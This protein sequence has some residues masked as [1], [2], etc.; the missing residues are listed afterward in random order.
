MF[1]NI[2][3]LVLFSTS[4][5]SIFSF[6]KIDESYKFLALLIYCTFL[7]EISAILFAKYFHSNHNVFQIF[8]IIE[9]YFYTKIFSAFIKAE[10]LK[11]IISF[12]FYIFLIISILNIFFLQPIS[13][14]NTNT[15]ILECYLI[16]VMSLLLFIDIRNNLEYHNILTEEVFWFN[17]AVFIFYSINIIIWGLRSLKVYNLKNPPEIVYN[18]LLWFLCI[19]L[20]SV[21]TISIVKNAR[22]SKNHVRG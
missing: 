6:N 19:I 17:S 9:Y 5:I 7:T 10:K 16:V 13:T 3:L 18:Q 4:I 15:I 11:K 21:F 12:S 20:Y 22:K 8:T 1:I 14:S 2:Y